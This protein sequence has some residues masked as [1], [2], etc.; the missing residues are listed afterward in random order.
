MIFFK[1]Y[2]SDIYKRKMFF[3]IY[4]KES[5]AKRKGRE[6]LKFFSN[7]KEEVGRLLFLRFHVKRIEP[8]R[9]YS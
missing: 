3:G 7:H 6:L 5:L 2:L 4:R 9:N 8:N 1:L